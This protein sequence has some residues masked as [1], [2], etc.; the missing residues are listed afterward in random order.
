ML[1]MHY[2][3][4]NRLMDY[5]HNMD[6]IQQQYVEVEKSLRNDEE[7]ARDDLMRFIVKKKNSI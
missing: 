2:F 7:I 5:F 4:Y 1:S 6:I 3:F